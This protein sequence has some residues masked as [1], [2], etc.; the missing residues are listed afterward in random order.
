MMAFC[1]VCGDLVERDVLAVLGEE[2]GERVALGVEHLGASRASGR[3]ELERE[4][5]GRGRGLL[6]ALGEQGDVGQRE[7]GDEDA[8][9][10][11]DGQDHHDLVDQAAL[12]PR[13]ARQ[14]EA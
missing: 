3:I 9:E 10:H 4:V 7:T 6:G 11:A 5:L 12:V 14:V 8:G 13:G 2:V 1:I